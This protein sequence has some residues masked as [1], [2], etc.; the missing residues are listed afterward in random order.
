MCTNS[1]VVD[2]QSGFETLLTGS[3]MA[4][5]GIDIIW[6]AGQLETQK[7][8]SFEKLLVDNDLIGMIVR[9]VEG[10]KVDED[11]LALDLIKKVGPKGKF[12]QEPHTMKYYLKE[13]PATLITDRHSR[14]KW[15]KL[16]SKDMAETAK[17]KVEEI[18]KTHQPTP[19]PKEI[20]N[21]LNEILYRYE[22]E[23]L[24]G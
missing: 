11:S 15:E 1:K 4:Q 14:R 16:G 12:L 10:I 8:V 7:S 13:H 3:I 17:Q 22:K 2:A 20:Q 5:S 24:I 19:L 21:R 9:T 18:L 23:M 6:G